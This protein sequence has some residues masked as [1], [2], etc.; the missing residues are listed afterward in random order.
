MA[1]LIAIVDD[2]VSV[3]RAIG[4]LVRSAGLEAECFS[5]AEEFLEAHSV[6]THHCLILDVRLPGISGRELQR[7]LLDSNTSSNTPII[8][9]SAQDNPESRRDALN[10]GAAAFFGKPFDHEILL[11]AIEK[12]VVRDDQEPRA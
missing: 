6:R 9:V 8:F 5:S 3:Q 7:R 10:A 11:E 12:A 2:E 4:R 1:I